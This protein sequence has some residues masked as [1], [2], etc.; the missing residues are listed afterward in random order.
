MIT[1]S[2]VL[3]ATGLALIAQDAAA[4]KTGT[5][6]RK[7][8]KNGVVRLSDSFTTTSYDYVRGIG[9]SRTLA[10]RAAIGKRVVVVRERGV[11]TSL[12]CGNAARVLPDGQLVNVTRHRY[13]GNDLSGLV[14]FDR[15]TPGCAVRP[16]TTVTLHT[17]DPARRPG[18]T[19]LPFYEQTPR[20]SVPSAQISITADEITSSGV[21]IEE[22]SNDVSGSSGRYRLAPLDRLGQPLPGRVPIALPDGSCNAV[23]AFGPA[24]T[25][26]AAAATP[27]CT[28]KF[29][30]RRYRA[31]GSPDSS[32]AAATRLGSTYGLT[33]SPSGHVVTQ[34][35]SSATVIDKTG[36][37]RVKIAGAGSLSTGSAFDA[38]GRALLVGQRGRALIRVTPTTGRV[39][40]LRHFGAFRPSAITVDRRGRIVIAGAFVKELVCRDCI[41]E[42]TYPEFHPAIMRV[43]G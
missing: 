33:V 23:A 3:A 12:S 16:G 39:E 22:Y 36:R 2:L 31:D 4:A 6:D 21:L 26:Y 17:S 1:R 40:T 29:T 24:K 42:D 34:G 43:H 9:S 20:G 35:A 37:R 13:G 19:G 30:L 32:F 10:P 27:V 14:T 41:R 11:S 15:L 18:L 7:F 5:L 25:V 38:K 8:G 28:S